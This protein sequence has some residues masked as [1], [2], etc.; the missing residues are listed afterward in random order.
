MQCDDSL[1]EHIRRNLALLEL[2]RA[3]PGTHR[4][5]AVAVAV[6]EE[7]HGARLDGIA[8]PDEWGRQAALILTRRAMTLRMLSWGT[9]S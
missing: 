7:G 3:D 5:A 2:H 1:K 6:A 4:V 8:A 9:S